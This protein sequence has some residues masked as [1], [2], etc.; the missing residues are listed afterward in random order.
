MITQL[1]R[2]VAI[3]LLLPR[4]LQA[5]SPPNVLLVV[6]DDQRPDTIA[7]LGNPNIRTPNLD[8][9]AARGVSFTRAY[10][11]YPICYASRAEILTGCS[12]FRA[13]PKYP[14]SQIDPKL[15]TMAQTFTDAD[16]QTW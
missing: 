1:T 13:F 4:L 16:Y 15:R 2:L 12:V 14:A 10:A 7:A 9:L 6:S 8:R 11:G 5:V 3:A